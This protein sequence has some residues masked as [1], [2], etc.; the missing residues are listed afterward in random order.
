MWLLGLV[1]TSESY[2]CV[3]WVFQW[4]LHLGDISL[5]AKSFEENHPS[6][7]AL[8]I[9]DELQHPYLQAAIKA[10]FSYHPAVV[11]C[12]SVWV[13]SQRDNIRAGTGADDVDSP[14]FYLMP[15]VVAVVETETCV[16]AFVCNILSLFKRN[17]ISPLWM[18]L[19][20]LQG[21]LPELVPIT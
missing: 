12:I 15:F 14:C 21:V 7:L 9:A 11:L 10:L 18:G 17:E 4:N 3:Q 5:E 20:R 13:P 2:F 16:N 19:L 1:C 6:S 8:L